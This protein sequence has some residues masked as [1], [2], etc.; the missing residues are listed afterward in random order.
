LNQAFDLYWTLAAFILTLFVFSYV[1]GDNPIF[2]IVSY[3]LVGVSAGYLAVMVIDF[4]IIPRLVNPL[5]STNSTE[6]NLAI[7][8]LI[9]GLLLV[10]RLFPR[11]SNLGRLPMAYMVGIGAAVTVG[12]AVLGT[13]MG[14]VKSIIAIFDFAP[15]GNSENGQMFRYVE[16]AVLLIGTIASLAYFQ[17]G[18]R[19]Y[20]QEKSRRRLWIE[21]LAWIG[22][23]F[24]AITLGALFAGV[25]LSALTAMIDRMGFIWQFVVQFTPGMV[26]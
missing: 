20:P 19:S 11:F 17:F 23:I 24:I 21:G 22:K 5:L 10:A 1:L 13:G 9:L 26:N 8:P 18:A 12:G 6:R 16:S 14:Q 3:I 7:V 25:Y 2:R 15:A 4:A